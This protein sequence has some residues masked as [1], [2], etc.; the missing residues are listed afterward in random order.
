[1]KEEEE[2]ERAEIL[3]QSINQFRLSNFFLK[4]YTNT[5]YI[6]IYIIVAI[7]MLSYI[8]IYYTI[9]ARYLKINK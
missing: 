9:I 6:F 2:K 8:F 5:Y 7:H 1:M 4:K 3:M